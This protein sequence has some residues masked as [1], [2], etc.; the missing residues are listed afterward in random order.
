VSF[1]Q[2][3]GQS[4][5]RPVQLG[6]QHVSVWS[7]T[8]VACL[9]GVIFG[10]I[11]FVVLMLAWIILSATGASAAITSTLVSDFPTSAGSVVRSLLGFGPVFV[12][13]A[14]SAVATI[15]VV[16]VLGAIAT[17]LYNVAVR[18]MG[19]AVVGFERG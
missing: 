18:I 19:G 3:D 17:A 7:G 2:N 15:I 1:P 6:V 12:F 10:V 8:K 11:V 16:T 4:A 5:G 14:L 9:I 13:A